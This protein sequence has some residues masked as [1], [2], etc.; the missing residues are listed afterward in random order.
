MPRLWKGIVDLVLGRRPQL[1]M[2]SMIRLE[3]W[4][5]GGGIR[6]VYS[7]LGECCDQEVEEVAFVVVWHIQRSRISP[8]I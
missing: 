6:V 2:C 7:F 4:V 3:G 5:T 1:Q 8:D